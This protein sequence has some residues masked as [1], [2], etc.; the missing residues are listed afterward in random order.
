MKQTY[1]TPKITCEA[2][3]PNEY[4]AACA[5]TYDTSSVYFVPCRGDEKK[6]KHGFIVDA[7][8]RL[9][10]I[11]HEDSRENN[12][13]DIYYCSYPGCSENDNENSDRRLKDAITKNKE[14]Y[15]WANISYMGGSNDET[16][17]YFDDGNFMD[18]T[19]S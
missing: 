3:A 7:T 15:Q 1:V 11:L 5:S 4:I 12:Q 13:F 2:F 19:A 17:R 14:D 10:F 9:A 8:D 18:Y 6:K 16:A